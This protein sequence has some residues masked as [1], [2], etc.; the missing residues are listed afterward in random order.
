MRFI[1]RGPKTGEDKALVQS[2]FPP[3]AGQK[4]SGRD[5]TNT[6]GAGA[7]KCY[8]MLATAN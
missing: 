7:R 4:I 8:E 6:D 5:L 1:D 2:F 3:E